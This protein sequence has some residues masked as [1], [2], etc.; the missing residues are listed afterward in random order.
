MKYCRHKWGGVPERI[1]EWGKADYTKLLK[2]TDGRKTFSIE[3]FSCSKGTILP[4]V[5]E[6]ERRKS[7]A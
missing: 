1:L 3:Y 6:G 4:P 7:P 2:I 5:D